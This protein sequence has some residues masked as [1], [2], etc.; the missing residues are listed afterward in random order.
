MI[1]LSVIWGY[2]WLVM[3]ECLRFC[4][5][6]TLA[7]LRTMI[8]SISLFIFIMVRRQSLRPEALLP[9]L[10][11]GLTGTTACI[12]LVTWSLYLGGVGKTAVLVYVMPFW[13]LILAWPVLKERIYGLQWPAVFLACGGLIL[14]IRPWELAGSTMGGFLAIM[15]G[16]AWAVSAIIT[17]IIRKRVIFDL[18]SLTAWQMFLGAV[19][20]TAAALLFDSTPVNWTPYFAVAL[21]YSAVISQ[22][23]ALLLWFYILQELPAGSASLGTL[24][25]PVIGTVAGAVQLGERPTGAELAGMALIVAGLAL[26]AYQGI[27]QASEV[28]RYVKRGG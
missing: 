10:L 3:K 28:S 21:F 13:V 12:G 24:A 27:L 20:L 23:V 9:T 14:V 18:V 7:A 2:N 19:P 25:T 15:G 4:P 17:K 26:L 1:A 11:L 5:P 6:L 8:G 22:A 16:V